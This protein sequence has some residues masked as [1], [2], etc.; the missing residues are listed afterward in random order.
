MLLSSAEALVQDKWA[1]WGRVLRC[2]TTEWRTLKHSSPDSPSVLHQLLLP[3]P[4]LQATLVSRIAIQAGLLCLMLL[5]S[6]QHEDISI[7]AKEP[8]LDRSPGH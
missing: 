2:A 8:S 5:S 4:F 3:M 6:E 7:R 1:V